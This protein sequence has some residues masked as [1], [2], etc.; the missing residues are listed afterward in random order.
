MSIPDI[1]MSAAAFGAAIAS[2]TADVRKEVI[3]EFNQKAKATATAHAEELLALRAA[4]ELQ[5]GAQGGTPGS[6][7]TELRT[8]SPAIKRCRRKMGLA[9][10]AEATFPHLT[11]LGHPDTKAVYKVVVVQV[12]DS[13]PGFRLDRLYDEN[14]EAARHDVIDKLKKI[15]PNLVRT[16]IEADLK[17]KCTN[18]TSYRRRTDKAESI[19]GEGPMYK[20][21]KG[22][23]IKE[24]QKTEATDQSTTS[25]SAPAEILTATPA[26]PAPTAVKESVLP[27][28]AIV[29]S[30]KKR[31]GAPA[32]YE[33]FE[34]NWVC[35]VCCLHFVLFFTFIVTIFVWQKSWTWLEFIPA[36]CRLLLRNTAGQILFTGEFVQQSTRKSAAVSLFNPATGKNLKK[37]H[38]LVK[39][40]K[41][42]M[43]KDE[44]ATMKTPGGA[45]LNDVMDEVVEWSCRLLSYEVQ[46]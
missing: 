9:F 13:I 18:Q 21:I 6:S 7:S 26:V 16:E 1:V 45:I 43:R 15:F 17:R 8:P 44:R 41:H 22:V 35:L 40:I 2:A 19:G 29:T 33:A 12:M 11:E 30:P 10:N 38:V 14:P 20:R 37:D 5:N 23:S 42:H 28:S 34:S 32:S 27:S 31:K 39:V 24:E 3:E 25:A 46:K 36:G 4:L